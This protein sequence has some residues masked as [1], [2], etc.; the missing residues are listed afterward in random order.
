MSWAF[1]HSSWFVQGIGFVAL[2]LTFLAFQNQHRGRI[3]YVHLIGCIIFAAHYILLSA[4]TGAL[5]LLIAAARNYVFSWKGNGDTELSVAW[6]YGFIAASALLMAFS[7]AGW[8]SVLPVAGI[9]L[10]TYGVWMEKPWHLRL[11]FLVS[12]FPWIPYT[13]VVHSYSGL[14]TQF[15]IIVSVGI[16]MF[17]LD[18][19]QF[20]RAAFLRLTRVFWE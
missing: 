8:I 9:I 1:L 3:L 6:L 18:K 19:E 2:A 5:M 4:Y 16:G 20:S 14:M 15:V 17:R 7:W 10:G 12:T 11:L 13:I